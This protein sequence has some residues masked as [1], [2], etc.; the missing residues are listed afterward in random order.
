MRFHKLF[1]LAL[2]ISAATG[3][4]AQGSGPDPRGQAQ[5]KNPVAGLAGIDYTT[6]CNDG[7][8]VQ[9]AK[10]DSSGNVS[11]TV[12]NGASGGTSAADESTFTEGSTSI[13]PFGCYYKTSPVS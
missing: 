5:S 4:S 6:N 11:V 2:L 10:V 3:V 7:P 13:T 1:I 9:E 8:C 12:T